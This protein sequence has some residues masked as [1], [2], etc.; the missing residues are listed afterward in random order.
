MTYCAAPMAVPESLAAG[1]THTSSNGVSERIRPLASTLSATPPAITTARSGTRSCSRRRYSSSTSSS[2][3]CTDAARSLSRWVS[4]PRN[5]RG[6]PNTSAIFGREH[7]AERRRAVG[8][9]HLDA[10]VVM[11]EVAEVELVAHAVAEAHD[12][13]QLRQER[14]LAVGGEAHQLVLVAE[15]RQPEELREGGVED[16]EAVGERHDA[17]HVDLGADASAPR[18]AEEVA[19]AVEGHGTPPCRYGDANS[20]LAR[21][22]L[23][24]STRC[25]LVRSSLRSPRPAAWANASRGVEHLAGVLGP[26]RDRRPRRAVAQRPRDLPRQVRERVAADRRVLDVVDR[27]VDLVEAPPHRLRG[28]PRLM[29]LTGEP[30]LFHGRDQFAVDEDGRRR[31]A[32][33]GVDAERDHAR[34]TGQ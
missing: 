29:L 13:A 27:R 31:V 28:E 7:R 24:C 5:S 4:S 17:L 18:R 33:I 21:C 22:A 12:V 14:R 26:R 2:R 25:S 19:H 11:R 15:R 10:L 16:A 32:V 1:C 23:W 9:R 6:A 3:R 20:A 34:V 30:L 8:P